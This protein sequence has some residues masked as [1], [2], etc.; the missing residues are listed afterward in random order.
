MPFSTQLLINTFKINNQSS[1][2]YAAPFSPISALNLKLF[3][4][5]KNS[6]SFVL[7]SF[8]F[9]YTTNFYVTQAK[10]LLSSTFKKRIYSFSF[11][12]ELQK[13]ILKKYIKNKTSSFIILKKNLRSRFYYYKNLFEKKNNFFECHVTPTSDLI[14]KNTQLNSQILNKKYSFKN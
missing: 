10:E 2:T 13:F 3:F 6:P 11:K 4:I 7:R 14:F 8:G 5:K 1:L 9:T 12:S